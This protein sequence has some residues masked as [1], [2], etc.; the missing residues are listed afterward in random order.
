MWRGVAAGPR[1][2]PDEAKQ[3]RSRVRTWGPFCVMVGKMVYSVSLNSLQIGYAATAM[4]SNNAQ[5]KYRRAGMDLELFLRALRVV[6][7]ARINPK[8]EHVDLFS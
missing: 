2:I 8:T 3:R 4:K 5:Y 1:E 6:F 7:G